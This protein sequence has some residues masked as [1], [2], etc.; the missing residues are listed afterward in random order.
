MTTEPIR[1]DSQDFHSDPFTA[2]DD[3]RQRGPVV[4]AKLPIIGKIWLTTTHAATID[5]LK[6]SQR[7]R[8]RKKAGSSQPRD[9]AGV[10]WWM[11][12]T[13]RLL[14]NNMLSSDDPQHR[15][16]RKAV[17]LA[18]NR[19]SVMQL[20][21][22]IDGIANQL[23]DQMD[24]DIKTSSGADLVSRYARKLPLAVIS[25][26]LGIEQQRR[27]EFERLAGQITRVSSAWDFVMMLRPLAQIRKLLE[28]EIERAGH[29]S[30]D[31]GDAGL[32]VNL[33]HP[34]DGE[35]RLTDD[36]LLAMV[37]LLLFAGHETTTHLISGS[38]LALFEHEDQRRW[39]SADQPGTIW[40]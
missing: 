16:L 40:R 36:E 24:S 18:F 1:I 4:R 13:I 15:R 12:R 22:N 20:G 29:L 6:D 17:D 34:H 9:V 30:G 23:L 35:K 2:F 19:R 39:L 31:D 21:P 11:P 38:V 37:F 26:L 33:L 8:M 27:T 3:L 25:D 14:A 7:F 32:I 28:G 5:M 10:K